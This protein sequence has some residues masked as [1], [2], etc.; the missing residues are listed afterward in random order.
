M[1]VKDK[2]VMITGSGRGI[3]KTAARM[4][5]ANGAK[6]AVCDVNEAT[7]AEAAKDL[8]PA[9]VLP[10]MTLVVDV[11]K[12]E[13]VNQAVAGITTKWGRVDVLINNAGITRDAM[14]AKMTETD[15]D[16]VIDVNLK[17]V[18][19]CTQAVLPAMTSQGKGSIINTSSIVAV[20]GNVGQTNY[21]AAKAGMIGMTKTWAKELGRKGITVNA[22]APGFTMTEM[23][24]T[25]P[26]KILESIK[27]KTPM[28][29]LGSPEDIGNAYLFL[30]SDA[31]SFVTGQVL[32]V[33]G[34]LVL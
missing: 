15:F 29:R 7:L 25:V 1:N 18:F 14:L 2:V 24:A 20:Y 22:V 11:S 8:D 10:L 32:G 27:D 33:D 19:N 23:L 16:Q 21:A 28:K 31:A 4:F 26:E 6:V 12:R 5:L 34:G 13:S 30:A 17:G 3:G 9:G